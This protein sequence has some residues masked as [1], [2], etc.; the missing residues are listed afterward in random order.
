MGPPLSAV[1]SEVH[2]SAEQVTFP[3]CLLSTC[4]VQVQCLV[5]MM[6]SALS[7]GQVARNSSHAMAAWSDW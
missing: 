3:G 5:M 6:M 1:P 7:T 2:G 4:A